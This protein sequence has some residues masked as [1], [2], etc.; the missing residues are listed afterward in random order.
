[1]GLPADR[2]Y[3][4]EGEDVCYTSYNQLVSSA[5]KSGIPR[6]SV[7]QAHKDT[8]AY[9]IFSSGTSGLPKGMYPF[10]CLITVHTDYAVCLTSS[11]SHHDIP[12]K[13]HPR[14]PRSDGTR[15][16]NS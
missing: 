8:L 5:R 11:Y 10:S 6:L 16:G 13:Y 3:L 2:I 4:L 1:M 7:R 9:L 14:H 15:L 12:W